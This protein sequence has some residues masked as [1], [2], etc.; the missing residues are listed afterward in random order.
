VSYQENSLL[1]EQHQEWKGE[2]EYSNGFAII[3]GKIWRGKTRVVFSQ[4]WM[5]M[6]CVRSDYGREEMRKV[7]DLI[8]S[9][10]QRIRSLTARITPVIFKS[11]K[12][13]NEV[14]SFEIK[15][16]SKLIF[17]TPNG[18]VSASS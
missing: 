8:D 2:A 6:R 12:D 16:S 7:K 18:K 11:K 10:Y 4:H 13:N 3:M 14:R 15:G 5:R 9:L 17:P 1:V